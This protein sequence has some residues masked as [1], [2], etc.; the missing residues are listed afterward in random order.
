[1]NKNV[2][3]AAVLLLL[4]AVALMVV[5][6]PGDSAGRTD[7]ILDVYAVQLG[8]SKD[9]ARQQEA[10]ALRLADYYCSIEPETF[11]EAMRGVTSAR[12]CDQVRARCLPNDCSG[13]RSRSGGPAGDRG[14]RG[15]NPG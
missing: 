8:L 5:I 12:G 3:G 13:V 9:E 7:R 15:S 10:D 4:V 1:M 14:D 11:L 6:W 2:A